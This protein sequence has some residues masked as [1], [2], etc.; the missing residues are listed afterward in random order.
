MGLEQWLD[1]HYRSQP[2]G[3]AAGFCH[4]PE[5][6]ALS[7][8]LTPLVPLCCSKEDQKAGVCE[9]QPA[10]D[11]RQHQSAGGGANQKGAGASPGVFLKVLIPKCRSRLSLLV[12][13]YS[14]V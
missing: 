6:K 14:L 10:G 9:L 8:N 3:G 1:C 2:G 5:V 12:V 13:F 7:C 4:V 11:G